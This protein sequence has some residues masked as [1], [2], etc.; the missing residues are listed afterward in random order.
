MVQ[1]KEIKMLRSSVEVLLN[2]RMI[3]SY[4]INLISFILVWGDEFLFPSNRLE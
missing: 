2:M 1:K 3:K 4:D